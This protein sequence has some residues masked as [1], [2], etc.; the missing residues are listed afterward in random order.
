MTVTVTPQPGEGLGEPEPSTAPAGGVSTVDEA[1]HIPALDGLR[2]LAVAGVLLYHAGHLRGGFLGVDL[3]FVLS[4]YLITGLLIREYRSSSSIDLRHFWIRRFRRL[5]PALLAM[6][7]VVALVAAMTAD[8]TDLARIRGDGLATIFYVANWHSIFSGQSYWQLFAA[9][10]PFEHTWSLAIEEQFY[11]IWPFVLWG[12]FRFTRSSLR[13]L[14]AICVGLAAASEIALWLLYRPGST[15]R[16]YFG[17]DT[18]GAAI[19]LGAALATAL[20]IWG[21]V[22]GRVARTVLEVAAGLC[23]VGLL[24]TWFLADGQSPFLYRGGFLATELAV[25]V[26]LAAVAHPIELSVS[27]G[28]SVGVLVW[29]G[30][31]SYGAYLW[32]WPVYQVL[33][34]ERVGFDGWPLAVLQISVSLALAAVSA[35]LLEQP[36]RRRGLPA[37]WSARWVVPV[38]FVIVCAV[39]LTATIGATSASQLDQAGAATSADGYTPAPPGSARV[40][41]VGDSVAESL[42]S[43][44]AAGAKQAGTGPAVANDGIAGC[45][46]TADQVPTRDRFNHSGIDLDCNAGWRDRVDAL[47]PTTSV[48]LLGGQTKTQVQVDGKWRGACDPAWDDTFRTELTSGVKDLTHAGGKVVL[49]TTPEYVSSQATDEGTS[50]VACVNRI[51]HDVAGAVPGVRVVDLE[52]WLCPGG[53]CRTQENGVPLRKDGLHFRGDGG[54][55]VGDW[56]NQQLAAGK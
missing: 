19:L 16:A 15:D 35:V 29:L 4:G 5:M 44:M 46:L 33:D 30:L 51:I 34:A 42:A 41:V 31:I 8:S 39:L 17:T 45:A 26:I 24:V 2:G 32:H 54:V 48:V 23:L 12:M 20:A 7:V 3:F 28:L 11:L 25:L 53:Q 36:I 47:K 27:R 21:P 22:R 50:Q 38:A 10:S 40:L 14:F 9:P 6:L 1:R 56:A 13:T 18:R 37:G 49:M 55:L 52:G 43:G